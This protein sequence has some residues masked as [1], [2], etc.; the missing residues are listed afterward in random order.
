MKD[1]IKYNGYSANPSDYECIDGDL[2][3]SFGVVQE[4]GALKPVL[5]PAV[6][7]S[8]A[9]GE[10]VRFIHES[11]TFKHYIILKNNNSLTWRTDTDDSQTAIKSFNTEIYQIT[12]VGNT[13]IVL[14]SDGMHYFLWKAEN[15]GYLYLGTEIPECPLSFGLQGEMIRTDEFDISFDGIKEDDLYKE[16]TDSNKTNI[17]SQVLAHV[18]KFIADNST[19]KGKFIYPF[20]LRYAYRLYDGTL[21]KH[22]APILMIASSDL[23]PQVMWEHITG[24]GSYKDAKLRVIGVLHTIDYAVVNQS[25]LNKLLNWRDI[26]NSV[27]VFIS[28]PIYTYDQNG[29][30]S[31][32]SNVDEDDCYCVCRHTNQAADIGKF[33]LR[34]QKN[35]FH[36]LYAFTFSPDELKYPLSRLMLPKRSED[37]VKSDIKSCSQFYFLTSV[38]VEHLTTDRTAINVDEGYLQSL[39]TREV[40]TDDYDSHDKIIPQYAFPYNSRLNLANIKKRLFIG[41]SVSSLLIYSNGYVNNFSD[42]FPTSVD[43]TESVQIYVYIKQDGKDIIVRGDGGSIGFRA[44]ILFF[45]YPNINAYKAV[46]YRGSPFGRCYEVPLERH[47]FLNGA[48]YFGGWKDLEELNKPAADI[49]SVSNDSE[50]TIDISNKI[51]TS[52]VNNPFYFPVLGINTICTGKIL[53]LCAAAKALSQGQFGQFPLYAFSTD[54]VW[55]LEVSST[56]TYSAKQPI[57]RDVVINPDS[58]TQI[59]SAVLFA[60]DRGIMLISGSNVQ[61]V[62]D[63]LKSEDLFSITDLPKY[64]A[65]LNVFNNKADENEQLEVNDISLL[66]FAQFLKGCRMVYDYAN[67][68][69][70]VYNTDVRYAYVYSLKSQSWGMMCSD[71]TESVNSY[72]EALAMVK[73]AKLVDFSKSDAEKITALIITRPFKLKAAID[74]FKTINTIIQRGMFQS[75]HVSQVLYGSNDLI[76][77]HTVW[78]SVDKIMRGFRGTPYKAYRLALICRLDKSESLYGCTVVFEPRMTNQVR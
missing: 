7:M 58:I 21:T 62:S 56:G 23:A 36:K 32:F 45:Y 51:Y 42:A 26:V 31:R 49:P 73:D 13:L 38:N 34:Y 3:T 18:N 57:T 37:R 33:P 16:F 17:T 54:G 50:R 61:C 39:V 14:S 47:D 67:Q 78:S 77:W 52:E 55:A 63:R 19:N 25:Y 9:E 8:L 53:G 59:D 11:A 4:D 74:S 46:I 41:H 43:F 44:P 66:P 60:T 76:H 65:L 48:F 20:L 71:I 75:G 12:S 10:V 30:C 72:P 22:S 70:I 2:A 6:I 40:M 28:K 1:E 29:E 27:D 24:H 35:D 68:H 64:D 69:I 15:D 5:P